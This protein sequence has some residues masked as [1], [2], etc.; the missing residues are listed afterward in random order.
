MSQEPR[1][2]RDSDE[3]RVPRL[4]ADHPKSTDFTHG[5]S[6]QSQWLQGYATSPSQV[7]LAVSP[8]LPSQ[9]PSHYETNINTVSTSLKTHPVHKDE[10][11]HHGV[12]LP[13]IAPRSSIQ[14]RTRFSKVEESR[15]RVVMMI[16]VWLLVAG[17]YRR[18]SHLRDAENTIDQVYRRVEA[19]EAEYSQDTTNAKA[20]DES[21]WG[22]GRSVDD[23]WADVWSEVSI[24]IS[25][26]GFF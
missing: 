1:S 4:A 26:Y 15:R 8:D 23:L 6:S 24:A 19:L 12:Q 13:Y 5:E 14:P 18:A 17:L 9:A 11:A 21:G 2:S 25:T 3:P 22:S 10:S 7:G 20:L 16:K